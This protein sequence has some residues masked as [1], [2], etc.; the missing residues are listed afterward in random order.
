MNAQ[1]EFA[2]IAGSGIQVG[3][4]QRRDHHP[5]DPR[6]VVRCDV[7]RDCRI[8]HVAQRHKGGVGIFAGYTDGTVIE[9]CDFHDMPYSAISLSWGSGELSVGGGA[10]EHFPDRFSTPT[11]AGPRPAG[12]AQHSSLHLVAA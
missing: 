10:Y 9:H 12:P 11:L 3:G 7:I 1:C 4:V 6:L 5:D 2:D 8:H